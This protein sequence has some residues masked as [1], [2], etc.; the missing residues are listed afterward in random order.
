MNSSNLRNHWPYDEVSLKNIDSSG[1]FEISSPWL[2]FR[3]SLEPKDHARA[4][5]LARKID[6]GDL[7]PSDLADL[8]WLFGAFAAYPLSY[9]LPRPGLFGSDLAIVIPG[10]ALECPR[11]LS[12]FLTK[13]QTSLPQTWLWELEPA[14]TLSATAGGHDPFTLFSVARRYHLLSE[15]EKDETRALNEQVNALPQGSE[16]FVSASS[17]IL[18]QNH[19]ITQRCEEVLSAAL[20]SCGSSRAAVQA[21][22]DAEAGHDKILEKAFSKLA[23]APSA[24][25]VLPSVQALMDTFKGAAENL[26]A[27]A[28]IVD[29]FERS[30]YAPEDPLAALLKKGGKEDAAKHIQN[31][32]H[33]NDLGGHENLALTFLD[34]LKPVSAEYAEQALRL[35]ELASCA[36]ILQSTESLKK[37][38]EGRG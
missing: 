19:Y 7:K 17:L 10:I 21:F 13:A 29:I 22:I 27:F 1:Q 38:K 5:S 14:L 36:A 30:D 26:L 9:L 33:I 34:A 18:R 8:N 31:H 24:I 23:V 4:L 3:F 20:P 6:A 32:R 2:S 12:D 35:A 25:P 15:V 37:I 16:A 28:M 11:A